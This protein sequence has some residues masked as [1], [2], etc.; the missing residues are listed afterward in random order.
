[1]IEFRFTP[2][3]WIEF[4]KDTAVNDVALTSFT[5]E[6]SG[7][8]I[9]SNWQ[10]S[11]FQPV[12]FKQKRGRLELMAMPAVSGAYLGVKTISGDYTSTV[13]V[14][15]KRT[16][17][18]SG[19]GVI[20]DDKNTISLLYSNKDIK[21]IQ[22]KDSVESEIFQKEVN[23]RRSLF[24]QMQVSDGKDL[25]FFYSLDGK[26]FEQLNATPVDGSFLP[27]WDRSL[28]VGIIAKGEA[29]Q[30]VSFDKFQLLN[31]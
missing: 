17:A 27:P 6:F 26:N 16:N 15:T 25:T 18:T 2:N 13:E 1:L 22:L 24:L 7:R 5:D 12:N 31:K 4:I 28:R 20:G 3:G 23:P 21:L 29:N 8:A 11:V 10:W 9:N 30:K 14:Q 19:I